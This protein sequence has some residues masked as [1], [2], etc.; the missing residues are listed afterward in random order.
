MPAPGQERARKDIQEIDWDGRK[1][2]RVEGFWMLRSCTN[3]AI[4]GATDI[5][6]GEMVLV[7]KGGGGQ[8]RERVRW[9]VPSMD[10]P[11]LGPRVHD[12]AVSQDR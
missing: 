8:A 4:M 7:E 9:D 3:W 11:P 1:I 12:A 10:T 6:R 2:Q 5:W